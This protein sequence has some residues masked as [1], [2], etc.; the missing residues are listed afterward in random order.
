MK[1]AVIVCE[2]PFLA[3]F[4]EEAEEASDQVCRSGEGTTG[5]VGLTGVRR[6]DGEGSGLGRFVTPLVPGAGETVDGKGTFLAVGSETD[7]RWVET[8]E[9][10]DS[11][12]TLRLLL[13]GSDV[14]CKSMLSFIVDWFCFDG[15]APNAGEANLF[16][17]RVC[18]A[19]P[20]P[21]HLYTPLGFLGNLLRVDK[22]IEGE[23]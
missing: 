16:R 17:G 1:L 4:W 2:R 6:R 10:D 9:L 15:D 3:S 19:L 22:G 12:P 8:L 20:A 14:S 13:S 11:S 5:A 21:S 18:L 23:D 7:G